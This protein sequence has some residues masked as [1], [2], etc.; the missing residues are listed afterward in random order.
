MKENMIKLAKK[1]FYKIVGMNPYVDRFVRYH[2]P[3]KYW[4]NRGGDLYFSE[5]EE[6]QTRTLRSEY[7]T[8]RLKQYPY[9]RLLEIGCGYGKQLKNLADGKVILIGCDFSRPQLLKAKDYCKGMPLRLV[10][11]DAEFVPLKSKSVDLAFSSAVILHNNYRKA[12]AIV[13][14]MIRVS[15]RFLAHNEDTDVTFSRYGYDLCKTYERLGFKIRESGTIPCEAD[16]SI[17]QFT[18]AELPSEQIIVRPE[19]VPLAFHKEIKTAS[20]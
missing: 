4:Q 12:Q 19:D 6:V 9:R 8:S 10:E 14:E 20:V 18:V 1:I 16:P 7:I 11:A 15:R 5:Q 3:R 2:D 13:S 17:T